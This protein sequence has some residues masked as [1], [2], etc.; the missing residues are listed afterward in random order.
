MPLTDISTFVIATLSVLI[1]PDA[2]NGCTKPCWA[3]AYLVTATS[4]LRVRMGGKVLGTTPVPVTIP[5]QDAP[6]DLEF[7]DDSVGISKSE[8]LTLKPGDNGVHKVVIAK[9]NRGSPYAR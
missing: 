1:T 8:Q 9:G 2:E 7:F 4:K 3:V 5:V 6:M